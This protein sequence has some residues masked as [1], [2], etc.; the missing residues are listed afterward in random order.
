VDI[1]REV[2]SS[3]I[4]LEYIDFLSTLHKCK[5]II[6]QHIAQENQA[7]PPIFLRQI[8]FY[9]DNWSIN[10]LLRLIDISHW[11]IDLCSR[12][13]FCE[14]SL[15]KEEESASQWERTLENIG[16]LGLSGVKI[17]LTAENAHRTGV[18]R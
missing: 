3:G 2:F 8:Y 10:I 11:S 4:S 6:A 5:L 7:A 14:L 13:Y 17:F 16:S 1:N 15:D 9:S 18:L 12:Y